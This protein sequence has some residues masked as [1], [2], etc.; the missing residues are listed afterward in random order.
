MWFDF[1]VLRFI[2]WAA[3]Q[4]LK[5]HEETA[6]YELQSRLHFIIYV[7]FS[8]YDKLLNVNIHPLTPIN[9]PYSLVQLYFALNDPR[10]E[11]SQDLGFQVSFLVL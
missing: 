4:G 9:H 5:P 7:T 1:S 2:F 3:C 10:L 11:Q 6:E 8:K